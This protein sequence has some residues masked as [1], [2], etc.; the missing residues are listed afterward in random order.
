M[1]ISFVTAHGKYRINVINDN[2][3]LQEICWHNKIPVQSVTFYGMVDGDTSVIIGKHEP[4]K[5]FE[6]LFQSILIRPDRN[7]DYLGVCQKDVK[8]RPVGNA[9]A[10]YTF[11][12]E[13]AQELLHFEFSEKQCKEYVLKQVCNF[14]ETDVVLDP[15]AKIVIGISGGGDSNTLIE[16][17]LNSGK[18]KHDQII[19]VMMLGIP[20]WDKGKSRAEA[21]CGQHNI[22][23]RFVDSTAV[24]QLLGRNGES[25]WLEDFEQVFPDADLEVLGTLAVRLSLIDVARSVGAQ[26][27]VTG[28]NLED[29]LA[30]CVLSTLQGKLP[31]PFPVRIIDGMP[32][33]Y[34]L[35]SIP[36]KML[37]GCY[38]KYSLANYEDRFPS[39]MIARANVYYMAQMLNPL[40]PGIEFDLLKGFKEL[41]SKNNDKG[42]FDEK[43]GFS[44]VEKLPM[45]LK[46]RWMMFTQ[47]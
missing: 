24:N 34:P 15:K 1:E 30:E 3:S 37:D 31:S 36:K 25:T 17:F 44:V 46:H 12:S 40:I 14:F 28:L 32:L 42:Y 35:Y 13:N 11:P 22:E 33:W 41:A 26:A 10:E 16:A 19:A 5:K 7:I 23:L 21:I 47:M 29:I 39:K 45:E 8:T 20:D 18:V 2:Q 38:P 43:L 27:I 9:V 4:I 6:D